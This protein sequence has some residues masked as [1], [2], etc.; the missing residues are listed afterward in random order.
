MPTILPSCTTGTRLICFVSSRSAISPSV[1]NSST[2][3]TSSVMMSATRLACDL[4][5]SAASRE[6]D[7]NGLLQRGRCR[8]VPISTRRSKSPS[9]TI[10]TSLPSLSSRNATDAKVEH[11][12][13]KLFDGGIRRC[14]HHCPDHHISRPH[15]SPPML[16]PSKAIRISENGIDLDQ[17]KILRTPYLSG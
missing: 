4:T 17:R 6:F 9:V 7:E 11:Q 3:Q 1:A 13:R 10:P 8:S 5:Y 2:L 14:G 12:P 16:R 15:P